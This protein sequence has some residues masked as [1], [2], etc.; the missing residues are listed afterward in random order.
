[1]AAVQLAASAFSFPFHPLASAMLAIRRKSVLSHRHSLS[2]PQSLALCGA[3]LTLRVIPVRPFPST[4]GR[5]SARQQGPAAPA[6]A[7]D[8]GP[9]LRGL[10]RDWRPTARQCARLRAKGAPRLVCA[11]DFQGVVVVVVVVLH[12]RRAGRRRTRLRGCLVSALAPWL[13][14]P[15]LS[16]PRFNAGRGNVLFR[17]KPWPTLR[18]RKTAFPSTT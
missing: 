15:T 2:V 12:V 13:P 17:S 8:R 7:A 3:R 9:P 14:V 18:A 16:H 1:M 10:Y 6:V 5:R 4:G 11:T